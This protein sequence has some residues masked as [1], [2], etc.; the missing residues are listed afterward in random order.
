MFD[1]YYPNRSHVKTR[2]ID[3]CAISGP[4]RI[5][6]HSNRR[7]RTIHSCTHPSPNASGV[8]RSFELLLGPELVGV[9]ALLLTAVDRTRRQTSVAFTAD[10]AFLC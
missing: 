7:T 1:P 5:V 6:W 9:T 8:H 3:P 2:E 10:P 4:F